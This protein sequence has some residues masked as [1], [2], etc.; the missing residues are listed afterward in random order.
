[1][2][3][4]T[5]GPWYYSSGMVWADADERVAIARADRN[6]PATLP[7]ERD[8]NA[9]LI[10]AAPEM[11]EALEVIMSVSFFD[12]WLETQPVYKLALAA[13]QKARGENQ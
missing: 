6:E 7:T 13:I 9:R 10:A 1:M 8:A 12:T 11:L 5:P 3:A 2:N 4:Y